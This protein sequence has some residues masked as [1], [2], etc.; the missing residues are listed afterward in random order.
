MHFSPAHIERAAG[1]LRS[2]VREQTFYISGEQYVRLCARSACDTRARK[3]RIDILPSAYVTAPLLGAP[4]R[5]P[6]RTLPREDR[7]HFENNEGTS[8]ANFTERRE[9]FLR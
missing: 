2:A 9:S 5:A 4:G 7:L 1:L 8:S 3:R 6:F